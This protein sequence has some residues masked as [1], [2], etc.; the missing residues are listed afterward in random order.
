MVGRRKTGRS[1]KL[2][3]ADA[4]AGP[5]PD[6]E[7][8]DVVPP[9]PP[10]AA[11]GDELLVSDYQADLQRDNRYDKPTRKVAFQ[12][13]PTICWARQPQSSSQ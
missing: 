13:Q 8:G 10:G 3:E 12:L 5:G 7:Q 11:Q 1:H 2:V 4:A 6:V 9:V